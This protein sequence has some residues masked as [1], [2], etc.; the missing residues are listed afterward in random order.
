VAIICDARSAS[1]SLG[2]SF[3]PEHTEGLSELVC[4]KL[5]WSKSMKDNKAKKIRGSKKVQLVVAASTLL[6]LFPA[7][8]IAAPN[9]N[10]LDNLFSTVI[11][12]SSQLSDG[13]NLITNLAAVVGD[14]GLTDPKATVDKVKAAATANS[15]TS[16]EMQVGWHSADTAGQGVLSKEGQKVSKDTEKEVAD[17]DEY[18]LN[19]TIDSVAIGANAQRLNSSQEIL[20]VMSDQLGKQ[21]VISDVQMRLSAIQTGQLQQLAAQ[22]A[23]SNVA[24]ASKLKN[25]L[26]IQQ[27]HIISQDGRSEIAGF[28]NRNAFVAG[29]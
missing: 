23:S 29:N 8:A 16:A 25:D 20:K 10:F 14:K 7:V 9:N 22:S 5:F 26:G 6:I 21:S 17:L 2:V 11:N 24:T 4:I 15:P 3:L 1:G 12:I 19:T 13:F 27:S 18:S 28:H